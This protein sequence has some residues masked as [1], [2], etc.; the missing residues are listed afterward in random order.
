VPQLEQA[1]YNVRYH[2]FEG[3]HTVPAE[4]VSAALSWFNTQSDGAESG[5]LR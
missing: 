3:P 4:M 5:N 1:G 2:E